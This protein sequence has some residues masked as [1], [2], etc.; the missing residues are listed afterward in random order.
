MAPSFKNVFSPSSLVLLM[1]IATICFQTLQVSLGLKQ[2]PRE[3]FQC[4]SSFL[5]QSGFIGS[6]KQ[7]PLFSSLEEIPH[8]LCFNLCGWH[9]C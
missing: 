4:Q 2:A 5:H 7:I 6:K 3:W 1:K 9:H 8:F